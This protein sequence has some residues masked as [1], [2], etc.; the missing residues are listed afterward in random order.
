MVTHLTPSCLLMCSMMRSCM[1]K[2]CGRPETSGWMVMGKMNSSGLL[3]MVSSC[4]GVMGTSQLTVFAV[5]I[6]KVVLPEFFDVSTMSG[7]CVSI[8]FCSISTSQSVIP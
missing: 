8:S 7:L 1:N 4:D 6:V 5:E 3:L 2:T